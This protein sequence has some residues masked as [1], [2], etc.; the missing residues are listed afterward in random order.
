MLIEP[1]GTI[2]IKPSQHS[3]FPSL[4]FLFQ[5]KKSNERQKEDDIT[6]D[7][8]IRYSIQ[9]PEFSCLAGGVS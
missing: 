9:L 6:D 5:I 7:R 8:N 4:W 1:L 3:L 2:Q